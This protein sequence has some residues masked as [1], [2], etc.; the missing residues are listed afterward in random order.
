MKCEFLKPNCMLAQQQANA[1][2]NV[3]DLR[4]VCHP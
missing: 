2:L 3:K 4:D 1:L